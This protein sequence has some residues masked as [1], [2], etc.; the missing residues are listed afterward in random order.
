MLS[1]WAV[2]LSAPA[3]PA[4]A[5]PCPDVEVVFARG[6]AEPPG[7]G[8]TGQAFVDALRSQVGGRSVGVYG[9]NY[10]ASSDFGAGMDFART[11]VDGISDEAAHIQSTAAN[12]PTTRMVL[13]GYSQGAVVTGFVTSAAVP[14]GV[15]AAFVPAPMAPEV[16]DH[17]AAVA[18]FGKPSDQFMRQYGAPPVVIGP[19]YKPKTIELCA[20]GDSICSGAA[21]ATATVSHALYSVNGMVGQGASFAAS[22]L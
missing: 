21:D 10:P 1:T 15:P 9:V 2:L 4:S 13:G 7:V 17:V 16:A 5:Q 8:G 19:L 14:E 12:C 18:L 22:R 11:V 20:P 3:P 6:T